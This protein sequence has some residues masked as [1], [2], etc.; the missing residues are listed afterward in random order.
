MISLRTAT[1]KDLPILLAFEQGLVNE[2]R[3]MDPLLKQEKTH[4]YNLPKMLDNEKIEIV[5]AEIDGKSVGCGYGK[6]IKALQCFT[7]EYF[8]YLGFMYTIPEARRKGVNKAVMEYLYDWSESQGVYEV[9]LDVYPNNSA[10][11]KS[12]EKAGMK[13]GLHMMR[14]DL[15]EQKK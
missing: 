10:A 1:H 3:P 9:R 7:Y 15:R 12:Y 8:C 6:I 2:E 5:I 14:I 13:T 11:I 4:Y